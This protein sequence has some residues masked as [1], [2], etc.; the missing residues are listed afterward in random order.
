MLQK[1]RPR[2]CSPFPKKLPL[3]ISTANSLG[4]WAGAGA[5]TFPRLCFAAGPQDTGRQI[6]GTES[7]PT[8][9]FMNY[10]AWEASALRRGKSK[11]KEN[12]QKVHK[13]KCL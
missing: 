6:T 9:R 3:L 10:S 7:S 1:G 12:V 8:T 11:D 13:D 4:A 5:Q 2:L